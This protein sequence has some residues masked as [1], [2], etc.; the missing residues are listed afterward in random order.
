M[1]SVSPSVSFCIICD[2]L[3]P[4]SSLLAS[5]FFAMLFVLNLISH[6]ISSH[7]ISS[8]L[9]SSH[10]LLFIIREGS[11]QKML[12]FENSYYVDE[13]RIKGIRKIAITATGYL[14]IKWISF[15]LFHSWDL[16]LV[17][18]ILY[19]EILIAMN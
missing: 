12:Q 5:V 17:K 13:Y 3:C 11:K 4:A 1:G 10:I 7:L 14:T 2:T 16:F 8:H 9:I 15:Q 18:N 6:L 19:L